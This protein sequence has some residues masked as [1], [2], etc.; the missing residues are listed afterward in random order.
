[1]SFFKLFG[2]RE[3]ASIVNFEK[4]REYV[5]YQFGLSEKSA[6]KREKLTCSGCFELCYV[7]SPTPPANSRLKKSSPLSPGKFD[8]N[9]TTIS[10]TILPERIVFVIHLPIIYGNFK[11]RGRIFS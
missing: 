11:S 8:I 9:L 3:T 7:C 6:R 4:G 10:L 5:L 2:S 1:M